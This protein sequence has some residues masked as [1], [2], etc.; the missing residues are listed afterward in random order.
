MPTEKLA[1]R[2][3][4]LEHEVVRLRNVLEGKRGEEKPWWE[5]ITDS[6]ARDRMYQEA[7]K[8]GQQ[9]RRSYRPSTSRQRKGSDARSRH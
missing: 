3:A 2:V 4:A 8:L 7:M 9:Q 1:A 5:K 6:F